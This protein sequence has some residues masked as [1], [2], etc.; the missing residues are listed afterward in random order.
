MESDIRQSALPDPLW[1]QGLG[2]TQGKM[3]QSEHLSLLLETA[4][5][6]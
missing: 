6:L 2:A 5:K 1:V 3:L 4:S